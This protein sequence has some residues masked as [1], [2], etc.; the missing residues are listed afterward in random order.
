MPDVRRLALTV[1]FIALPA[2]AHAAGMAAEKGHAIAEKIEAA[3]KGFG[4]SM[5]S[6]RMVLKNAQGD[7]S[8]RDMRLMTLE[9]PDPDSGDETLVIVDT[10]ADVS[11]TALLT[12]GA[13]LGDDDQW[14]YLPALKRV[15]RISSSNRSG[16]FMGS[17][18]AYEDMASQDI[19][20]FDWRWLKDEA[21]PGFP[22]LSC[23]VV[24]RT[25]Q[26]D[27]SGYS[28]EIIWVDTD[29][30]RT[31]KTEFYD[32]NGTLLKILRLNR[33]GQ[34]LGKYWRP[35]E[36]IMVNQQTG[37]ETDIV[38]SQYQFNTGMNKGFFDQNN[39]DRVK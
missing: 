5:V 15:K 32:R 35:H 25:P 19:A 24:E 9:D 33:Y 27:N 20:K 1:L 2:C 31:L 3:N 29:Q 10:P 30:Y 22:A 28:K 6:V 26:Y 18:F 34:Y 8:T 39:L 38:T 4:D 14:I 12:H 13:I 17:E 7:Q 23:A 36:M 16:P 21:C 37:K 11:G